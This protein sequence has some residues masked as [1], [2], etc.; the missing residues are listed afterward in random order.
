MKYKV[1]RLH[2]FKCQKRQAEPDLVA[3][4]Y[5]F[6][7]NKIPMLFA[8]AVAFAFIGAAFAWRAGHLHALFVD[9]LFSSAMRSAHKH[10]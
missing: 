1:S 10:A 3:G 6:F 4:F 5:V 9:Q 2:R 8:A 7:Y